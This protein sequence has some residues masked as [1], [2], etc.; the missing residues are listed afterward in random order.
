VAI[1]NCWN[2]IKGLFD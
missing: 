1:Q 2:Y